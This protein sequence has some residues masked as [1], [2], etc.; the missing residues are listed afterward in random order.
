MMMRALIFSAAVFCASL[1]PRPALAEE[2]VFAAKAL[3]TIMPAGG[4]V[5]YYDRL[6]L[7]ILDPRSSVNSDWATI[8]SPEASSFDGGLI[9]S[10]DGKGICAVAL[11]KNGRKV[12]GLL[13][14]A[15]E[16][17]TATSV[18][19]DHVVAIAS[20][21]QV[22]ISRTEPGEARRIFSVDARTQEVALTG[23]ISAGES[24]EL[25]PIDGS[26][27]PVFAVNADTV[28]FPDNP[29]AVRVVGGISSGRSSSAKN[30]FG[31]NDLFQKYRDGL[32][33]AVIWRRTYSQVANDKLGGPFDTFEFQLPAQSL[34][35]TENFKTDR[36][37]HVLGLSAA[38]ETLKLETLCSNRNDDG[39]AIKGT[40][41]LRTYPLFAEVKVVGGGL[42]NGFVVRV[43]RPG[44]EEVFDYVSF[45]QNASERLGG[46]ACSDLEAKIIENLPIP[47]ATF[48]AGWVEETRDFT[49]SDGNVIQGVLLRQSEGLVTTLI[50]DVY[51]A[52]GLLRTSLGTPN[53]FLQSEEMKGVAI[54]YPVLPGDGNLG[55]QSAASARSPDRSETV[56]ALIDV[57]KLARNEILG[58][59]GKVVLRGGSAGAWLALKTALAEPNLVDEV[60]AISAA[61]FFENDDDVVRLADFFSTSDSLTEQEVA[62]CGNTFFRLIHGTEDQIT[63]I[64]RTRRFAGM[65]SANDCEGALHMVVG[66]DHNLID[67][68]DVRINPETNNILYWT[69][70]LE[71]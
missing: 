35:S 53:D 11:R 65:M 38:D 1:M 13:D 40:K 15:N 30:V 69:H 25:L 8:A 29:T 46:A 68:W 67:F 42:G 52:S 55:W 63:P 34:P 54:F 12:L 6:R 26:L 61:Y 57:V 58:E 50:I 21:G 16:Q 37:G 60:V 3:G 49:V 39:S 4:K 23:V 56:S 51:G 22:Y 14:T 17:L 28:R 66:G 9:C 33:R 18:E 7:L 2:P 62:R 45:E 24:L 71:P 43:R 20:S 10:A 47:G 48:P 59:D 27:Q 70:G 32:D 19:L 5:V 64:E 31:A 41:L 44:E 36:A